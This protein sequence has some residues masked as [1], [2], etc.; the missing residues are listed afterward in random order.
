[1]QRLVPC[2]PISAAPACRLDLFFCEDDV[3]PRSHGQ[4]L[5]PEPTGGD[6]VP[7][8]EFAGPI[9]RKADLETPTLRDGLVLMR[10]RS[11]MGQRST[12]GYLR[13][14]GATATRH[15]LYEAPRAAFPEQAGDSGITFCILWT[16]L[17]LA[18][19]PCLGLSLSLAPAS[20]VVIL[21]S[22]RG[23]FWNSHGTI[24]V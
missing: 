14:G 4:A 8:K 2:L 18:F 6:V 16:P 1:V 20:I 15:V 11:V 19:S 10:T 3:A 23:C 24:G 22:D 5:R 12:L 9:V 13:N 17:V 7:I 21:A